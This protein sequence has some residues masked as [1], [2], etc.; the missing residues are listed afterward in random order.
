[1]QRNSFSSKFV[2]LVLAQGEL[3]SVDGG[4]KNAKLCIVPHVK[5]RSSSTAPLLLNRMLRHRSL[6]GNHKRRTTADTRQWRKRIRGR[7]EK[8]KGHKH[9]SK[10]VHDKQE[11]QYETC[12]VN[13]RS[14]M[15]NAFKNRLCSGLFLIVV[16]LTLTCCLPYVQHDSSHVSNEKASN[17][18][19]EKKSSVSSP[20]REFFS[21]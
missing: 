7:E 12:V 1:M 2:Q 19:T 17:F 9:R 11:Y 14:L 18:N 3:G 13:N 15:M 21:F 6:L 5:F 16:I 4:R 8:S 10:E 20:W